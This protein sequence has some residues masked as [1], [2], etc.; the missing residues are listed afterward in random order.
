MRY[1]FFTRIII[2]I[3]IFMNKGALVA[4]TYRNEWVNYDQAYYKFKILNDSVYRITKDKLTELGW[5]DIPVEQFQ[6]WKNGELVPFYPSVP[7]GPLPADGYL[8]FWGKKNDGKAD[9]ELYF[10]PAYQHTQRVSITTDSSAYFLSYNANNSG[11]IYVDEVNNVA[12]NTLPAETSFRYTTGIYYTSQL[13]RGAA[14]NLGEYVYA[15]S[16]DKGE[17]WSSGNITPATGISARTINLNNIR[18]ANEGAPPVLTV[19][20]AGSAPNVR[21]VQISSGGTVLFNPNIVEFNDFKGST[22]IDPSLV[23]SNNSLSVVFQNSSSLNTDRI[24]ISH[25]ELEYNRLFHFNSLRSFEFTLAPKTEGY[26]LEITNFN[27]NS[28]APVLYDITNAKRYTGVISGGQVRFALPGDNKARDFVLV[29]QFATNHRVVE[30]FTPVTFID[31]SNPANQG[32]YIVISNKLLYNGTNGINPVESYLNYRAS[33]MGGGYQTA[34]ADID[35]LVD[36][37]GY[38]LKKHPMAVR[39]FIQFAQNTFTVKPEFFFIIGRGIEY[40][41]Y[42]LNHNKADVEQLNLVPTFGNPGSDNLFSAP[43]IRVPVPVTPI[44]RLSVVHPHEVE[45]YLDK[46]KQHELLKTTAANTITDKA[47]MKN[48]VHVTG[49]SSEFL[50]TQLCNYMGY[51]RGALVGPNMGALVHL[52]CKTSAGGSESFN[53]ERIAQ[54]FEEGINVLSYF[55]HSS[56]TTL[57]FN[58]ESPENYNN[59]NGKYPLFLVNGCNAGNFFTY[60]PAR[61]LINETLTENFVLAKD[62]GAIGFIASTHYGVVSYLNV[63]MDYMT[64]NLSLYADSLTVGELL[65]LSLKNLLDQVGQNSFLGRLHVEQMTLHG[66]PAV[67][68]FAQKKPDYIVEEAFVRISPN[69]ISVAEINY[70]LDLK[71]VNLGKAVDDSLR[72]RIEQVYPDGTIGEIFNGKV[73]PIFNADSLEFVV[74]IIATRDRGLNTIRVYVNNDQEIDEI[75]FNNNYAE[76]TIFIYDDGIRPAY[77][78]QYSIVNDPAQKLYASTTNP[79]ST[80]RSYILQID[81]T[82]L[83]SSPLKAEVTQSATGGLVEFNAPLSYQD[84]RVYYWRV[85]EVPNENDDTTWAKSSF[86]YKQGI[87]TGFNQSHYYQH[88]NSSTEGIQ[89]NENS[90]WEFEHRQNL[91]SIRNGVFPSA[92]SQGQDFIVNINDVS[93]TSS[94]CGTSGIYFV[95]IDPLTLKPWFNGNSGQPGQYNSDNICGNGRQ[96]QFQFNF[97]P[98]EADSAKRRYAMDFLD[99]IPDGHYV[100]VRNIFDSTFNRNMYADDLKMDT[101]VYGSNKSL[102]HKL[103]EYGFNDIDLMNSRRS[104]IFVF[105]K[106]ENADF[107]PKWVVSDGYFDRISLNVTVDAPRSNGD[108]VSPVLGPALEWTKINWDGV[109]VDNTAGDDARI[110]VSLLN[111]AREKQSSF[112]LSTSDKDFDISHIDAE[113]YP[114]LQFKMLNSDTVFFTPYQL[115]YWRVLY[116]PAPEGAVAPNIAFSAKDTFELGENVNVQLAFKNISQQS[117]DS[118]T[119]RITVID[120][121]NQ[122]HVFNLPKFKPLISGD[123]ILVN[124]EF[125]SELFTGKNT[126]LLEVNPAPSQPEQYD[127]NNFIYHDFFVKGD[128]VKPVLDVTFDGVHILSGDIVSAKP[129]IQVKMKDDSKFLLLNDTSLVTV[130]LKLPN[131]TLK[132]YYFNNNDTLRFIPATSIDNNEATI[133]FTPHFLEQFNADGDDY[134]LI[135]RG[136]DR[137]G[138]RT[139]TIDYR[140]A[141]KVITKAMISNMLNYPNPFSTST[142]FVFTITGSEVPQNFK[143]Q[144]LTVTGKIVREITREELGPLNIGRNITEFKWDGTDQFGQKLANGVYLYR[145]VTS[146]NGNRLEKYKAAGDNTDQFFTNG[147]GKMYIMR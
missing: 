49:S 11:K 105:K 99:M 116:L 88:L 77:P 86:L 31:Y 90:I 81:T 113:Q 83:F 55:G 147:Y 22:A 134:E 66:D 108:I 26:Y 17:F 70:T 139:G 29:S 42:M 128:E 1:K 23:T 121:Y 18:F 87:A 69:H 96:N 109:S 40:R 47:W 72:L 56:A 104:Y 33:A 145:V 97:Q 138:N 85:A 125:G 110:E 95:V 100:V 28:I 133:E 43:D 54:L 20:F 103:L 39:N 57:E 101:L 10:D 93:A 21:T 41:E 131:G 3:F 102:Y 61:L 46:V 126:L 141:F 7:N 37:F 19:G 73:E 53:S 114:Y 15:S 143:I 124:Y 94:V 2:L 78:Y 64:K 75:D 89:L 144:I 4:Q 117:F 129:V 63:Y 8:E 76:K 132:T 68:L 146:L 107:I 67:R 115:D 62:K 9:R 82:E 130:Q 36:Q 48:I 25:V 13:H 112:M 71:I 59:T 24:V 45:Q 51:Y 32:E 50:G 123:T 119:V 52:F 35:Q 44:G 38:G 30:R 137:S 136:R 5:G 98:T 74:P 14:E 60:Y 84:E 34:L 127:F 65:N 58:I 16:F 27:H 80:L 122:S 111:A 79:F 140:V 135:V 6:L 106:N 92:A 142:A 12:G 120:A 91:F 118:L